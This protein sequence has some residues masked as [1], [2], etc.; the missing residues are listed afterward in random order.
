MKN[1]YVFLLILF[2]SVQL[3]AQAIYK[4]IDSYKLEGTRELKIQLPRNYNPED[5]RSYP[6]IIVLDGDYLFEPVAGN[7][8]YQSY[9]EDI[10][11]C[12]VVGINQASSRVD[13]FYYDEETYFPSHNGAAFYEFMAAELLPFIEDQYNASNFRIVVGHDLSANFINYYMFK[14]DPI[15]RAYVTLSPDFA[16]EMVNRLQQR[17]NILTD[18]TFYYMATADADIKAIRASVVEADAVIK[19][20]EN[21]KFHYKFD[22]FKDANHYSLVGRGIPKALNQIF[23]L[24]KPINAKEYKEQVLTYEGTPFEYLMKKYADIERFYGFEKKLIENDVRA[25]AAASNKKGDVESL[26]ELS[27]LVNKH[28]SKSMLS[29]YYS[30]MYNEKIGNFKRALQR[31]KSGLLLEPSQTVDKEIMLDKMY[32]IQEKIK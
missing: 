19:T 10:P 18:E 24:F 4:T 1:F 12:I 6:L 9:W 16:P 3:P 8:D 11:D 27:K 13:D 7:I 15:F 30:G 29:A 28:F 2:V 22:E 20:V 23:T 21:E 25:I 32:E 14:D 31:Y 17:M 5:K 26:K